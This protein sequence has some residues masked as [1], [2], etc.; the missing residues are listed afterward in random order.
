M[1]VEWIYSF[2]YLI[3]LRLGRVQSYLDQ[4]Y[5]PWYDR[6]DKNE[7]P[8]KKRVFDMYRVVFMSPNYRF[9]DYF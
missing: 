3:F 7:P 8:K 4:D 2:K 9:D 1:T 5:L 6:E